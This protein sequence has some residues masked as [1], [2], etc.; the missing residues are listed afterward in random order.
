MKYVLSCRYIG[1]Q[2]WFPE[3]FKRL[4]INGSLCE[5]TNYTVNNQ[6]YQETIVVTAGS[7]FGALLGVAFV[8]ILGSKGLL[9]KSSIS[10]LND[11]MY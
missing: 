10:T 8:E 3:Y 11:K 6:F 1:V 2:Q 4:N 9:S 7:L 5:H